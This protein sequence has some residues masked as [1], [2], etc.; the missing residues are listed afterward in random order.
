MKSLLLALFVLPAF[1]MHDVRVDVESLENSVAGEFTLIFTSDV[2]PETMYR[3]L[4]RS[5]REVMDGDP[6]LREVEV[7]EDNGD[8]WLVRHRYGVGFSILTDYTDM[9]ISYT[10]GRT[11]ERLELRW[12][13]EESL[14]G[15]VLSNDGHYHVYPEGP[16][17]SRVE[18]RS[19]TVYDGR[20]RLTAFA[21]RNFSSGLL[22]S[23]FSRMVRSAGD[24]F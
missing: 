10:E 9:V 1:T 22:R 24:E 14:D 18:Y 17:G 6:T 2:S 12:G 19:R 3:T 23:T 7:L 5:T 16:T 13:L 4:R 20:N 8:S 21:L 11:D 15:K